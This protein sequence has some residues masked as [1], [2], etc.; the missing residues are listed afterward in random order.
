MKLPALTITALALLFAPLFSG[1]TSACPSCEARWNEAKPLNE[2][3][4]WQDAD[5]R[6]IILDNN[7]DVWTE[8]SLRD[9]VQSNALD[10]YT[11]P[12]LRDEIRLNALDVYSEPT[13]RDE[14]RLEDDTVSN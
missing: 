4:V 6:D 12:T 5:Q 8:P 11:E 13:L 14:I 2:H 7:L 9:V 10:V 1:V 3:N